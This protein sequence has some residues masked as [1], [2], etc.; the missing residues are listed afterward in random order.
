MLPYSYWKWRHAQSRWPQLSEER[1]RTVIRAAAARERNKPQHTRFI[2]RQT[3]LAAVTY[4]RS[5]FG[6]A[7][8]LAQFSNRKLP[9]FRE[10]W[11]PGGYAWFKRRSN[12]ALKMDVQ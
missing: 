12:T 1:M 3:R 5:R 2:H 8:F 9:V 6:A 11:L 7:E 4:Y 10:M